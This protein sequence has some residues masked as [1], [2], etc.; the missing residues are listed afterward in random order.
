ME[1]TVTLQDEGFIGASCNQLLRHVYV[2]WLNNYLSVEVFAEHHEMTVE[3]AQALIE[4]GRNAMKAN[5]EQT[6]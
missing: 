2:E 6:A 5:E 1:Q 4:L 3:D